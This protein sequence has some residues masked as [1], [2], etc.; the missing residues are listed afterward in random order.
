MPKLKVLQ[1]IDSLEAGGAE[2]VAVNYANGLSEHI[3]SFLCVTRAEGLLKKAVSDKV[4]YLFLNKKGT[5]DISA[6]LRLKRYIKQHQITIV[7]A[8]S[9]SFFIA[10]ISKLLG[11]KI[12]IVWHD[13]YGN[14]EFLD[15]RDYKVLKRASKYFG[16]IISVNNDLKEWAIKCLD[17]SNVMYLPNFATINPNESKETQLQGV[18]GKRI[19]CLANLRPQKDHIT[20]IHAFDAI[21]KEH[22]DWTLHLVGKNFEDE[23]AQEVSS[24]IDEMALSKSVFLYGSRPDISNILRQCSIGVLSSKSEGLPVTLL[25]YGLNGLPVVC[26][27]VGE[28][29]KVVQDYGLVVPQESVTE[30]LS[31]IS[32]YIKDE[33][34]RKVKANAYNEHIEKH[35][36]ANAVMNTLL[37]VYKEC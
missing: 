25:E 4:Q 3:E 17:C 13:H 33:E 30:I 14:S 29:A 19:V 22:Q 16:Q 35:Y 23:Y 2:R 34:L 1:I 18:D 6:I 10:W 31:A 11:A 21:K 5:L 27:D 36:S 12:K 32:Q 8:H 24:L 28:C 7:H 26:T 37:K 15:Q 9:S 20:L